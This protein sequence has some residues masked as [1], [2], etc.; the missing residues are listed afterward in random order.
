M[1]KGSQTWPRPSQLDIP[2]LLTINT[3]NAAVTSSDFGTAG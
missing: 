1:R 2:G 3:L